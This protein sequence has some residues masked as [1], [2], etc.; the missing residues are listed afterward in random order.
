MT[1]YVDLATLKDE[2]NVSYD[3]D[4]PRFQRVITSVSRLIDSYCGFPRRQFYQ[5]AAHTVRYFTASEFR[6]VWIDDIMTVDTIQ[7]DVDGDGTFENTWTQGT[8]YVMAP[9]NA[10]EFQRPFTKVEIRTFAV[11]IM[12]VVRQGLKI[13]G[14]WGWPAVPSVVQTAC[15]L[16]CARLFTRAEQAQDLGAAERL[17]P[18]KLDPDVQ[19]LLNEGG[20]RRS[21]IGM[22]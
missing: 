1:D 3:D 20:V 2:L 7:A 13:T 21:P 15:L 22:A 5:S 8:D 17:A 18:G 12:P 10:A 4:N 6:Q 19:A 9:Y 14:T 16:Q 11:T